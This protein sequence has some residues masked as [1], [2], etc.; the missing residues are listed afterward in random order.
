M[1]A[2]VIDVE[3]QDFVAASRRIELRAAE[4]LEL[5]IGRLCGALSH[6]WAM[7]GSDPAGMSW[8]ASYDPAMRAALDAGQNA[9]NALHTLAAMFA[10]TARNYAA[11][12]HASTAG[13]R[14]GVDQA[15]AGLAGVA[16][17]PSAGGYV[18]PIC[19]PS[20]AGGAG[21]EP[22]GWNLIAHAVGQVW[23]NGHQ[24]RLRAAA[25]AWRASDVALRDA[26]GQVLQACG[27][28]IGDR[29]PEADDMW[30]VCSALA[31]QLGE[32]ADVHTSLAAAC[33]QLAD[34]ID[35]AHSEV[36]GELTSLAEW[37]AAIEA[38]SAGLA[39]FSFGISEL[40]GQAGESTR[41]AASAARVAAIIERFT[42]LARGLADTVAA[43][44]ARADRLAGELAGLLDV[45]LSAAVVTHVR[46]LPAMLRMQELLAV[47][48]LGALAGN[49]PDIVLTTT[50]LE[51]KFKHAAAFGVAVGR[52]RRG[53]EE[54]DLAIRKFLA[55]PATRR[56]IGTYRGRQ[57]ILSYQIRSRLVVVQKL[58]G[59]FVSCWRLRRVALAHVV[60]ERT[61]GG[62]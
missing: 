54:F 17:V 5:A 3:T 30:R 57:V 33:D 56:V 47:R 26:A 28:A 42:A 27:A 16:A 31:E 50:Q 46:T 1:S 58:D 4:P 13:V 53:F 15:V 19:V 43:V 39:V 11:A 45:R 21:A 36:I 35:A 8:A 22:A 38:G 60:N 10:Q 12:E 7:A 25:L 20:A 52:G 49:F 62:G 24:D 55:S 61:L 6:C 9:V 44:T 29:L 51:S 48:R 32:V 23:P 14:R 2:P 34:H 40:V 59:T 18:L 41:I 37:T